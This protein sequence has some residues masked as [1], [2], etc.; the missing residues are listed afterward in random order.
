MGG[1]GLVKREQS[2]V[3]SVSSEVSAEPGVTDL[4]R[5]RERLLVLV[6][7]LWPEAASRKLH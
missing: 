4:R 6:T 7:R 2:P 3:G 5:K 1:T